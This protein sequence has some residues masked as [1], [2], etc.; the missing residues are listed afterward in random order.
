[1]N[2]G[3]IYGIDEP[4]TLLQNTAVITGAAVYNNSSDAAEDH[5]ITH[6]PSP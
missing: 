5:T 3:K 6:Y 4:N 1:M 2:S